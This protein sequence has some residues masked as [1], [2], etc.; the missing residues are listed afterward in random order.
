MSEKTETIVNYNFQ[1]PSASFCYLSALLA[2][3]EA[4]E[5]WNTDGYL[6]YFKD[7]CVH[8]ILPGS[9]WEP[10]AR[11]TRRRLMQIF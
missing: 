10:A 5:N 6:A 11:Y 2:N 8:H 9:T 3:L 1:I 7:A 4:M